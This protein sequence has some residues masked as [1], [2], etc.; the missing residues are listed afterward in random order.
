M[1]H[2]AQFAAY[3]LKFLKLQFVF[4]FT[5]F[6]VFCEF[7]Y[8]LIDWLMGWFAVFQFFF[9]EDFMHEYGVYI[10]STLISLSSNLCVPWNFLSSFMTSYS[11]VIN[12]LLSHHHTTI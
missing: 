10:I 5:I 3:F 9:F 2:Q 4:K 12:V 6:F 8:S 1:N 7:I 11:K